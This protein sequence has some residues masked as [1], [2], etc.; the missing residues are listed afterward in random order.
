MTLSANQRR[1]HGLALVRRVIASGKY[2]KKDVTRW[3]NEFGADAIAPLLPAKAS[4][5][6]SSKSDKSESKE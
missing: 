1:R 4:K 3:E 2:T 5:S 6:A